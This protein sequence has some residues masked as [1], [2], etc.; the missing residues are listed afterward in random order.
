MIMK[1]LICLVPR[2]FK[3]KF[4]GK[5]KHNK[6]KLGIHGLIELYTE[7]VELIMMNN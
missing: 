6:V 2:K 1:S 3:K 7:Q 4:P 5:K